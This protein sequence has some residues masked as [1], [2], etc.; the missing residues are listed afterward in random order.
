MLQE[1]PEGAIVV[2]FHRDGG[3]QELGSLVCHRT[4]SLPTREIRI[5]NT[6]E[7]VDQL[8]SFIAGF[9]VQDSTIQGKWRTKCRSLGHSDDDAH[10]GQLQFRS[11][12]IVVTF[13]RHAASLQELTMQLPVVEKQRTIKNREARLNHR[14][15]IVRPTEVRHIQACVQWALKHGTSLT[16]IGGGHSG[17]CLWPTVVG[18]DMSAFNQVHIQTTSAEDGSNPGWIIIV[19]AGCTSEDIIRAGKAAGITV[20]LGA[21]PSVG[22]GLWLQGGIGHLARMYGLACDSIVGAVLVC[23]QTRQVLCIGH[24]P[25]EH[26]PAGAIRPE[27]E[28]ELL[29]A[30][31]GAGTNIG[32]V[33]SVTF[34]A[35]AAPTYS[36]KTWIV[37]LRNNLAVRCKLRDFDQR[38]ARKLP[39]SSSA[40]AYLYSEAGKL[41]LGVAVFQALPAAPEAAS[42]RTPT[43]GRDILGP[44]TSSRLVDSIGLFEVDMYI[45]GMHGGHGGG[46]TSS[47]KRCLFLK[48]IGEPSVVDVLAAAVATAPSPFYETHFAQGVV[49]WVYH[50][51]RSILP[52]SCGVYGA[53]LGPDPR[54]TPLAARAFGPNL[55]RL[56]SLK[57]RVD[58]QNVL[59]YA[60]QLPKNT[61]VGNPKLIVLITGE[62]GAGK[63]YCAQIW[64]SVFSK[65]TRRSITARTASISYVAKQEYA[66]ASGADF[67]RLLHDR[68][69][70]EQHR[71]A[72]TA[73]YQSQVWEEPWLPEE[74]FMRT[75][76]ESRDVDVLLITGMRDNAPVPLFSHLVP[77]SRLIEV[78]V[79]SGDETRRTRRGFFE[80]G[81]PDNALDYSPNFIFKNEKPGD[82]AVKSFAERHLVPYLHE[83]LQRLAHMVRLVPEFPRPGIE[84]RHV[85]NIVQR[86]GGLPLCTSLL[87]SHFIGDWTK[88][89]V[90]ACCEAGGFVYAAP[91]ASEVDKPLVLI[92]EAGKLPPP[93]VSVPKSTSHIGASVVNN[94]TETRMELSRDAIP[95]S[96]SVVVVDD[97]LATGKTL[98]A[99]LHLLQE[100]SVRAEDISVMVVAEFPVHRGRKMLHQRGFGRVNVQ[101]L[102]VYDGV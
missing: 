58:P 100:A 47:F 52:L 56:A 4:A 14:A 79:T 8:N 50:V 32:I 3:L 80:H 29:W 60:C 40:D 5:P 21:R 11:P 85:L 42:E 54:D 71:P 51:A 48:D 15:A 46:K 36:V 26:Q 94:P 31:R 9:S 82:D 101:S 59:A 35:Y 55:S 64:V 39:R 76:D 18:V 86:P 2:V 44:E 70:K 6:D 24:V 72:L 92:R 63:D 33:V 98:C 28:A 67:N 43:T 73:F 30:V 69:Y 90:I 7:A 97:V 65:T 83:D 96:A 19:G 23:V 74:H 41:H 57:Q 77:T 16:V 95:R 12:E 78:R 53:D 34:K 68:Q 62:T 66:A 22:A 13:T 75:V 99:V 38:L 27:N 84:F 45:S 89:D 37:P 61:I 20:P 91:L 102:L 49:D 93:T 25:N 81:L 10:P 87:R 1:Q 88:V 17:H